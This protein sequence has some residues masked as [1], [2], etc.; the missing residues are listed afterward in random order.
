MRTVPLAAVT[1]TVTVF[2][3][4]NRFWLPETIAAAAASWVTADMTIEVLPAGRLI[5]APSTTGLPLAVKTE[6][7]VLLLKSAT[8]MVT[9]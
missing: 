2:V 5:T 8:R 4:V 9:E 1:L 7:L 3:P 6:R